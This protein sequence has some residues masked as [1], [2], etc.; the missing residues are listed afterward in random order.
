MNNELCSEAEIR[1]LLTEPTMN[2]KMPRIFEYFQI[3]SNVSH[4]FSNIFKRFA[5]FFESFQTFSNVSILPVL[6]NRYILTHQ[7]SFLTQKSI[8]TPKIT[9]KNPNFSIIPDNSTS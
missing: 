7:P 4:H 3:F 2:S 5:P 8:S 6:P 1:R 9:Q